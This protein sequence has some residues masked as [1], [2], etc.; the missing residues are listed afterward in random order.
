M[1]SGWEGMGGEYSGN[2]GL[3]AGR[4]ECGNVRCEADKKRTM[5]EGNLRLYSLKA[6]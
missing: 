1:K 6:L 4:Q 3:P 2:G 5:Q